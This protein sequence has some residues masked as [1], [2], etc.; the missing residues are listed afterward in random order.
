M[1]ALK[2]FKD[3]PQID[4]SRRLSVSEGRVSQL[5]KSAL[6]KLKIAYSKLGGDPPEEHYQRVI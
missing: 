6:S 4:I 5:L 3:C 1:V 2:Y